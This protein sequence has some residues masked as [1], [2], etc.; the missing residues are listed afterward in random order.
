MSARDI[1][2]QFAAGLECEQPRFVVAAQVVERFA[3]SL[4][5]E[6]GKLD[7]SLDTARKTG[8]AG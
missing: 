4:E 3:Q 5:R 1:V 8:N 7:A 2:E 6:S